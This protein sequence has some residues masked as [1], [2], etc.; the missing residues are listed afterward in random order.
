MSLLESQNG[1]GHVSSLKGTPLV[2]RPDAAADA[3]S[4]SAELTERAQI[5]AAVA[6]K[7]APAVDRAARFPDEAMRSAKELNLLGMLVPTE[8]GG[9][10]ASVSDAVDVCYMLG[11]ACG[12]TGL[13]FAMH[14]R[15]GACLGRHSLNNSWHRRFAQ[16]IHSQHLLPAS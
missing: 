12:S 9:D 6:A 4:I 5:V 3:D 15:M 1:L 16:R 8:L 11:R 10:G 13:S 7:H 14:Q 2:P